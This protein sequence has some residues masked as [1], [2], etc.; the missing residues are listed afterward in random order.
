MSSREE[1]KVKKMMVERAEEAIEEESEDIKDDLES[2]R[3]KKFDKRKIKD[4][5]E[6][7]AEDAIEEVRNEVTGA[8]VLGTT[9]VGETFY[10]IPKS[11]ALVFVVDDVIAGLAFAFV[12]A[13]IGAMVA[14]H[15]DEINSWWKDK[16]EK[17]RELEVAGV[18]RFKE[19][20]G[21]DT[22]LTAAEEDALDDAMASIIKSH[23][24][25]VV[26][27][28]VAE[29][30]P[31]PME[32]FDER[33][34]EDR[35]EQ[36]IISR[37]ASGM[38]DEIMDAAGSPKRKRDRAK[39]YIK[40]NWVKWT[41]RGILWDMFELTFIPVGYTF[42]HWQQ[43][44]DAA[45]TYHF[46][47]AELSKDIGYAIHDEDSER[48]EAMYSR[49]CK[50]IDDFD[51]FLGEHPRILRDYWA[52]DLR[53]YKSEKEMFASDIEKLKGAWCNC[54]ECP[55]HATISRVI[56]ADTIVIREYAPHI[57]INDID[58]PELTS[59]IKSEKARAI[60]GTKALRSV[61]RRGTRVELDCVDV[62]K[63]GRCVCDVTLRGRDIAKALVKSGYAEW[64]TY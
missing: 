15:V 53:D 63:Y 11:P 19:M 3:M 47:L 54:S 55:R 4:R 59:K 20:A 50:M 61:L 60:S 32:D 12:L 43:V 18:E 13:T 39:E 62:D 17:Q 1:R 22:E 45:K 5:L 9:K 34:V 25:D 6:S 26:D 44:K 52:S 8:L 56:D 7:V 42:I 14:P 29:F 58:A 64:Q 10:P 37:L 51:D 38:A 28:L 48:A 41:E 30:K 21:I 23:Y 16:L 49:Y 31:S 35:A 2:G 36:I 27:E 57:R 33:E 46:D 24:P 40:K